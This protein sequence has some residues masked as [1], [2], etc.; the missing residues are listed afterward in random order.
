MWVALRTPLPPEAAMAQVRAAVARNDRDVPVTRASTMEGLVA[1]SWGDRRFNLA[2]LATFAALAL[3]LAAVGIHGVMSYVVAQRTR[4]IGVRMA[5]GARAS[6]VLRLVL[7]QGL[8]LAVAGLAAGL[9]AALALRRLMA[10][11]LF[12][13]QPSDPITLGVVAAVMLLIALLACYA[14]A[15]RASRVDPAEALRWE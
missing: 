12:G 7:R 3:T 5:L 14:P 10:S 2:L 6:D 9:A 8:T 1:A 15:R 4:E 13:V 11:M